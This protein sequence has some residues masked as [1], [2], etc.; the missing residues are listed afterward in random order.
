MLRF[1]VGTIGALPIS[2]YLFV[3]WMAP[4]H[5]GEVTFLVDTSNHLLC[6]GSVNVDEIYVWTDISTTPDTRLFTIGEEVQ[7]TEEA[8]ANDKY[9]NFEIFSQFPLATTLTMTS[10]ALEDRG[11]YRCDLLHASSTVEEFVVQVEAEP[12]NIDI[13]CI[14][15]D[16][17]ESSPSF[18]TPSNVTCNCRA[19][20][21]YPNTL[22]FIG[23]DVSAESNVV[24]PT[25]YGPDG[26]F[27]ISA[28]FEVSPN[29]FD[30]NFHCALS[31]YKGDVSTRRTTATYTFRPPMCEL[32]VTK[33]EDCTTAILNCMCTN[34]VPNV[35]LYTFYD[36]KKQL[37]GK[38]GP[39]ATLEVELNQD[40]STF[41]CRGCNGVNYEF[42]RLISDYADCSPV[43]ST[44]LLFE[45]Y[46]GLII[47]A[48]VWAAVIIAV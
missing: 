4:A 31:G 19:V 46:L 22:T 13:E 11:T 45:P 35:N 40:L 33:D 24:L 18:L 5:A 28:D 34:A 8:S 39:S 36:E 44:A 25:L 16:S 29:G 7:K 9:N 15:S 47:S 14:S 1:G 32:Q 48:G 20:G 26:S 12:L 42:D 21:V 38:P 3:C 17:C 6:S 10:I 43:E 41:Y 27:D 37:I 2:L 30:D 23:N